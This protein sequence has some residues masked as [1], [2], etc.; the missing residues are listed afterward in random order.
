MPCKKGLSVIVG[1]MYEMKKGGEVLP[2]MVTVRA[3]VPAPCGVVTMRP[4]LCAKQSIVVGRFGT[5]ALLVTATVTPPMVT[6]VAHRGRKPVPVMTSVSP[7]REER[8]SS[9]S[10]V[11]K[12]GD[13][14]AGKAVVA[15]TAGG[16]AGGSA[17]WTL[18]KEPSEAAL[19]LIVKYHGG[20]DIASRDATSDTLASSAAH[21]N[22]SVALRTVGATTVAFVATSVNCVII[23]APA[24][25]EKKLEMNV[26]LSGI[27]LRDALKRLIETVSPL[28]GTRNAL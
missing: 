14:K 1:G 20:R 13:A 6:V 18:R 12:G 11:I 24:V 15:M 8:L 28:S 4:V 9:E 23:G 19:A 3:T 5:S 21:P 25:S 17:E 10:R 7:P 27:A 22:T 2:A 16:G 26:A